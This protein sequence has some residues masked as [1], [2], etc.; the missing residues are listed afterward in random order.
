[1]HIIEISLK[2]KVI[3]LISYK[4]CINQSLK[5]CNRKRGRRKRSGHPLLNQAIFHGCSGWF[6]P[7]QTGPG[8][9]AT[10]STLIDIITA[11]FIEATFF[12][13]FAYFNLFTVATISPQGDVNR[14]AVKNWLFHTVRISWVLVAECKKEEGKKN[15]CPSLSPLRGFICSWCNACE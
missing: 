6:H 10:A 8:S 13:S 1:M 3:T 9:R 7:T 4:Y 5:N 12:F 2:N 14:R 11:A 15:I